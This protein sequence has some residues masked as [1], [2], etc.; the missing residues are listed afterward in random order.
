MYIV[1]VDDV[2]LLLRKLR[3]VQYEAKRFGINLGL[4]NTDIEAVC[5]PSNHGRTPQECL[6]HVLSLWQKH[7][8]EQHTWKILVQALRLSGEQVIANRIEK[9]YTLA[10]SGMIDVLLV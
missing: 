4:K 10:Q 8:C 3:E 1:T 2:G 5:K 9:S 7:P 6:Q